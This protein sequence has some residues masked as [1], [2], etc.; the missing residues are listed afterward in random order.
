[1]DLP[2]KLIDYPACIRP[3]KS[4]EPTSKQVDEFMKELSDTMKKIDIKIICA[5]SLIE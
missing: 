1:M 3:H 4:H 5:K 2:F